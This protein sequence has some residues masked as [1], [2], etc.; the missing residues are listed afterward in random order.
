MIFVTWLLLMDA[1]YSGGDCLC[2]VLV[3]NVRSVC[4]SHLSILS[5]NM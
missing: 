5:L 3:L 2:V 4:S 1:I